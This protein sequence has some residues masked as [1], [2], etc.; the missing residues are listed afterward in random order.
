MC[1]PSLGKEPTQIEIPKLA[2]LQDKARNR[3]EGPGK[4]GEGDSS[5]RCIRLGLERDSTTRQ[6]GLQSWRE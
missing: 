3:V 2:V 4:A 6:V 5:G 1:S